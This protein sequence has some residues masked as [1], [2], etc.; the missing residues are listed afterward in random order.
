MV[1]KGG[2]TAKAAERRAGT[3]T[4]IRDLQL[5]QVMQSQA[6]M[7]CQLLCHLVSCVACIAKELSRHTLARRNKRTAAKCCIY[8]MQGQRDT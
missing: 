5:L 4:C 6:V 2:F 3:D 8:P 7:S 1:Y